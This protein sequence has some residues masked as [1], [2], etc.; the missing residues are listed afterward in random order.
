M[1]KQLPHSYTEPQLAELNHS[2]KS[3]VACETKTRFRCK[4]TPMK[5]IAQIKKI[6][7]NWKEI[8]VRPTYKGNHQP[9]TSNDIVRTKLL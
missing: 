7:F 9:L 5:Y 4:T 1:Y 3:E 2:G 6:V 8:K